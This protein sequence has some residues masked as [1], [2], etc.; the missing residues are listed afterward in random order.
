MISGLLTVGF[1]H[2]RYPNGNRTES[3]WM[4]HAPPLPY[5]MQNC[6]NSTTANLPTG[7]RR[8][9]LCGALA[10]LKLGEPIT[11]KKLGAAIQDA[12]KPL[13]G[14]VAAT[15][16]RHNSNPCNTRVA[17]SSRRYAFFRSLDRHCGSG[18]R[19]VLAQNAVCGWA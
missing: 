11:L 6:R 7:W 15:L 17:A 13:V 19:A 3:I 9:Q 12:E 10:R 1:S 14:N 2:A 16:R 18:V 4:G 5:P 8:A